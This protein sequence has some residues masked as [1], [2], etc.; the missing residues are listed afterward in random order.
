MTPIICT[1]LSFTLSVILCLFMMR[2][3]LSATPTERCSHDAPTPTAGGLSFALIF[4]CFLSYQFL[5]GMCAHS[6]L[7]Y[8]YLI[9]ACILLIVS[10][11]DDCKPLSY[12][13]RLLT[14]CV[15]ALLLVMGGGIIESPV[16]AIRSDSVLFFQK[17]LT[18]FTLL[19]LINAANFIDGLNGL[20]GICIMIT[21]A[22][23]GFWIDF[24]QPILIMHWVLIAAVFGFL[25]FNFPKGRIFMGDTGSTFLGLTLGFFSLIA[26]GNYPL[27][28]NLETAIFNK[29]FIFTLLPMSFLWFDVAFT[30]C[31]RIIRGEHLAEAH[32][33]HMI[34]ILFDKGYKHVFVTLLYAF[35]TTL[36]GYLTYQCHSE[37]ISFIEL[38]GI[39]A[40]L[41]TLFVLFVF[42][43]PSRQTQ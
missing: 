17:I 42:N 28:N 12:R 24:Y 36:M 8:N 33:D 18:I 21:L 32:R 7:L 6:P 16:I 43:A 23:A 20:L 39:Y 9:A 26:Q 13:V 5:I 30:L 34:H 14:Q 29:G 2:F 10:F 15:C 38:L 11:Y 3:N 40:F 4:I 27:S 19:S 37:H 1:F 35:G 25:I 41:Q 31:R 22:F